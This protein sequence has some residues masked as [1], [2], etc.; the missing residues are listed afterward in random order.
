MINIV[1]DTYEIYEGQGNLKILSK[2]WYLSSRL[3]EIT[4]HYP[5][6]TTFN[7]GDEPVF[8]FNIS[9]LEAVVGVLANN[10]NQR[11]ALLST[12]QQQRTVSD[13]SK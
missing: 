12:I 7:A 2:D 10:P 8:Y 4:S 1:T 3:Q 6:G 5:K 13:I 11:S 9:Q